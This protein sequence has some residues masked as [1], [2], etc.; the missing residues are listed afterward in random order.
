MGKLSHPMER[1]C[2]TVGH[3][4]AILALAACAPASPQVQASTRPAPASSVQVSSPT[5]QSGATGEASDPGLDVTTPINADTWTSSISGTSPSSS[6]PWQ[7]SWR[8]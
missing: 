7:P 2:L 3:A 5:L 4:A 1:L 8:P 6:R